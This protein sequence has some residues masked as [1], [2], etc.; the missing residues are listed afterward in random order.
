MVT[1]YKQQK[2]N[3]E[4]NQAEFAERLLK[5]SQNEQ[6]N[7]RKRQAIQIYKKAIEHAETHRQLADKKSSIAGKYGGNFNVDKREFQ[8]RLT[9]FR[10][11]LFDLPNHL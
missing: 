3:L 6:D 10:K 7:Q 11:E 1:R 5:I 2:K 9:T 8:E 4:T